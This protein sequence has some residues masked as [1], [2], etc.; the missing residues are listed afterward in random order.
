MRA[1]WSDDDFVV[2]YLPLLLSGLIKA[3]LKQLE[4]SRIHCWGDLHFFVGHFQGTYTRPGNSWD[5]RNY[6]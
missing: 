6:W 1:R 4:L 2:L 3:W 5:L